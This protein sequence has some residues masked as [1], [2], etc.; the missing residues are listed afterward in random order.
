VRPEVNVN[1]PRFLLKDAASTL[2]GGPDDPFASTGISFAELIKDIKLIRVLVIEAGEGNRTALDKG[3]GAL[4]AQLEAKWTAIV[5][6]PEENVG[7]YVRSSNDGESMA[8]LALLVYDG[9][10]AVIANVV[11]HVSVGKILKIASKMDKLPKDLLKKLGAAAVES[12]GKS[13]PAK[14]PAQPAAK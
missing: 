8:G 3:I 14:D 2:N 13:E 4:R 12:E 9:G 6:V 1:L 11:G 5:T 7:I 10:D